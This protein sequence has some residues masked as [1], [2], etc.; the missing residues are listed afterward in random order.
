MTSTIQILQVGFG[1]VGRRR[2][3]ALSPHADVRVIGVVD[4]D[5]EA[6][7]TARSRLG[8]DCPTFESVDQV[9]GHRGAEP[10]GAYAKSG[11]PADP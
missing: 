8:T 10:R 4:P 11:V 2:V 6:R 7:D 9:K 5:P 1:T 3:R